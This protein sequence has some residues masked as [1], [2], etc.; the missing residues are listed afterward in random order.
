MR[1]MQRRDLHAVV[2][3]QF[4]IGLV[5]PAVLQRLVEQERSRIG[6]G[7][8]NLDGVR[9][10]LG[11]EADGLFDGLLG[12]ARQAHDEGAV[13]GDAEF[14]AVLG[15]AAGDVDPHALLDVVQDL[16][17]AGLV[18]D[19]KEPQAVVAQHLQRL[20]RHIG[21]GVARPGHAE[22][23]QL[24]GDGLGARQ[25]V[26]EGVVVEEELLHL[27]ERLLRPGDLLDDVADR[28][29]AVAMAADRLRPQAEGA[30][31]FA[32]APGI[33]REIGMLQ[34][35]DEI[36]LDVEVALI[37]RRD[38]RQAVHVLQDRALVVVDDDARRIAV[39]QAG[40]VG[41]RLVRRRSP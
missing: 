6:R 27:G 33:D 39:G 8:R 26:G 3:D 24:L 4:G 5:E 10:D 36:I 13:D 29:G 14:V 2:V 12:L 28:A 9:I 21:L 22:L 23:A 37:D 7:K 34:V 16:L 25:I 35:A 30:A 32:A 40:D 1:I 11:G 18:A 15:E 41:P 19:Q 31:R 17:I 20:A 38:E